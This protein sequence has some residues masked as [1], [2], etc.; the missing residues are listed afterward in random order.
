[1]SISQQT[2]EIEESIRKRISSTPE[3]VFILGSG[4]NSLD[5]IIENVV[6]IPYTDIPHFPNTQ[7]IGHSG[8]LLFGE[9]AGRHVAVLA[10][11][12]H[13]Y[14]GY[15]QATITLPIRALQRLGAQYLF[16]TNATGGVNEKFRAG[17]LMMISD[18]INFIGQNPLVGPHDP[19]LGERFLDMTAA[20]DSSI[21]KLARKVAKERGIHLEEGVYAGRLG[22]DY[23]T[24]AEVRMFRIM[25]AD[26]VGMSVI[27]EVITARHVGMRVFAISCICNPA[28]EPGSPPLEHTEVV[29]VTRRACNSYISLVRGML[30]CDWRNIK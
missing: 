15:P 30:E 28:L 6:D 19:S 21:R 17:Q 27:P 10:G 25:G 4:F 3:V 1:M 22:P 8:R 9:L 5:Q 12:L 26:A 16:V 20:Y 23:E 18:H 29:E 13:T 14:E 24:P 11:R 2:L 7:V